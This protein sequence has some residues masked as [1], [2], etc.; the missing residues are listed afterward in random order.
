[1]TDTTISHIGKTNRTIAAIAISAVAYT[2]VSLIVQSLMVIVFGG[3]SSGGP[4]LLL[5]CPVGAAAGVVAA[6]YGCDRFLAAYWQKPVFL[7]FVAVSLAFIVGIAMYPDPP[8]ERMG[9]LLR[10]LST[11]LFAYLLFFRTR[12]GSTIVS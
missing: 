3:N 7:V 12:K 4:S 10:F 1:M 2:A 6:R 11:I 5:A 9:N 8:N